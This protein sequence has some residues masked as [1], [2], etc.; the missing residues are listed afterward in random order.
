MMN[1]VI[2]K[3]RKSDSLAPVIICNREEYYG[4]VQYY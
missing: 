3:I 1:Y 2:C 4:K